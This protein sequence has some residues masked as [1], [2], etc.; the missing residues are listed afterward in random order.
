V[1]WA[2]G[3]VAL[4]RRFGDLRTR[5]TLAPVARVALVSAVAGG[6]G[7]AVLRATDDLFGATV[8]GSLGRVLVGTVV[9]G[10][11]ALA[12]LVVARIP[13]LQGLLASVRARIGRG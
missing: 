10:A 7:W 1:G 4:R 11:T 6:I 3:Q 5:E 9:I 12:G 8:A 2:I 13:E